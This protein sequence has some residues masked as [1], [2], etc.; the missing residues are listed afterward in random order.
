MIIYSD[1]LAHL[2]VI[3]NCRYSVAQICTRENTLAQ[4]LGAPSLDDFMRVVRS[5]FLIQILQ[6]TITNHLN[7]E[8]VKINYSDVSR[9]KMLVIQ[10]PTVLL[11]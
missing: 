3:I 8:Q 10:I 9:I 7:R 1:K 6:W 11:K 2:Q 4:Y 5:F